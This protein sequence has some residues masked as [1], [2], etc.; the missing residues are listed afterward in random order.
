MTGSS[1]RDPLPRVSPREPRARPRGQRVDDHLA[2][3][4]RRLLLGIDGRHLVAARE[5]LHLA[6]LGLLIPEVDRAQPPLAADRAGASRNG[7]P[8]EAPRA[9]SES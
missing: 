2:D 8:R 3:K 4:P 1:I 7:T 5:G 6:A 9:R